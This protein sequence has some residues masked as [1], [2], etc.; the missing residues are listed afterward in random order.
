MAIDLGSALARA[1]PC[2][3][4]TPTSPGYELARAL[5]SAAIDRRPAAIVRCTSAAEVATA[6]RV[7]RESGGT[8]SVRGGG[9]GVAGRAL[10]DGAV[11]LDLSSMR[12]VAV[13]AAGRR[14]RVSAG[15]RW[16]DVDE[17][18]AAH[19]LAT[20][21]GLVSTTG[22][23]GLTLGG[24]FG[25]LSREHGLACDNVLAFEAVTAD[26]REV[27]VSAGEHPELFW[28]LRGGGAC[29]LVVVT[30]FH[31]ALHPLSSVTGG[32]RFFPGA[33]APALLRRWREATLAA[34]DSL[35][36]VVLLVTAPP[37]PFLP[38]ALHGQKAVAV[39]GCSTAPTEVAAREVAT[40][41]A[42]SE[43]AADL[44]ARR[45]YPE[46]QRLQ[47]PLA[48][49]G[50]H[51][52]WRSAFVSTLGDALLDELVATSESAPSP[53]TEVHLYRLGGAIA[54]VPVGAT[55]FPHREASFLV[56]LFTTW[57]APSA[58]SENLA[59]AKE[60]WGRLSPLL[61]ATASYSNFEAQGSFSAMQG[62]AAPG[63]TRLKQT[64]DPDG[65]LG[66]L[67]GA[68]LS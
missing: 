15:A 31:F 62:P 35:G 34:A 12:E 1:L 38:T 22:V 32:P 58:A 6:L 5:W 65:L 8:V 28:G 47:D 61:S 20:P 56:G 13:D 59:W 18:T 55:A 26:G 68:S 40:L 29:G 10:R 64:W 44:V 63:L 36:S 60:R 52:A 2:P 67:P 19:G 21:G 30:A 45:P 50:R 53:L 9:H 7:T 43:P 14:A 24:G 25:W 57:E 17:A 23:G 3:V 46:L 48:P 37:A 4:L 11:L 66:P 49:P 39:L 51:H 54:R 16:A 27:R 33:G 41:H 42:G